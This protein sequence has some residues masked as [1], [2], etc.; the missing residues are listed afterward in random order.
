MISLKRILP[1][2]LVLGLLTSLPA[3]ASPLEDRL[4]SLEA[5]LGSRGSGQL[6]QY[7]KGVRRLEDNLQKD[8]Y[9]YLGRF[10]R[11]EILSPWREI[12]NGFL[13]GL[14][15]NP[16]S[17]LTGSQRQRLHWNT[18]KVKQVTQKLRRVRRLVTRASNLN[19]ENQRRERE[20]TRTLNQY[21]RNLTLMQA[22]DPAAA[23][24]HSAW[25]DE[26]FL[27]A[28]ETLRARNDQLAQRFDRLADWNREGNMR[29]WLKQVG[30]VAEVVENLN[31]RYQ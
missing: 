16:P 31:R 25:L 19:T 4:E 18:A 29:T 15:Q 23:R 21:E 12:E 20:L 6:S 17:N 26:N 3:D 27:P 2:L 11:N 30:E 24:L 10:I 9:L 5:R 22:E 7:E 14:A 13:M 1:L 28:F 8:E